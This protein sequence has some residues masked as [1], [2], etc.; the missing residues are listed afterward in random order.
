MPGGSNKLWI[1]ERIN[2]S[3]IIVCSLDNNVILFTVYTCRRRIVIDR[4]NKRR[5]INESAFQERPRSR[6]R[7]TIA[8]LNINFVTRKNILD[9]DYMLDPF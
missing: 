8:I 1:N 9:D 4:I 2:S 7:R 6:L 5:M 3:I